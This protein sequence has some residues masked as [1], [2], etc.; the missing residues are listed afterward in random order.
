MS[1]LK[2]LYKRSVVPVL[3]EQ[4]EY[5]NVMCVPKLEKITINMGLSKA[6]QD[7]KILDFAVRDMQSICAQKP[8]ITKA[9]KAIAAFKLREGYPI[10]CMVTLRGEM[11]YDFFDRLIS[12]ALPRVRDFR[13]ISAKSFD[14]R[15]N[16]SFGLTEQ[17]VFPEIEY[18]KVDSIRGLSICIT[19]SASNDK[20]ALALISAMGFPFKR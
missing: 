10:G 18:D 13:G 6:I 11:M 5:K 19:T 16:F 9:R 15:G 7:K 20:E 1:R 14:G 4:F 3:M 2:D 17:I 8:V 12:F